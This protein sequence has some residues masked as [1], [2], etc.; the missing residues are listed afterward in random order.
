GGALALDPNIANVWCVTPTGNLVLSCTQ[1]AALP[2][3][4]SGDL[5]RSR[6]RSCILRLYL[7]CNDNTVSFSGIQWAS[8]AVPTP[9]TSGVDVYVFSAPFVGAP[10]IGHVAD[11]AC[12]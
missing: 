12:A 5:W 1:L 4:Q 3:Q 9:S 7:Y 8:G 10:F 2:V 11:Q 6:S